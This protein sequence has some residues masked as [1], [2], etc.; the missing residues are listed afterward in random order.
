LKDKYTPTYRRESKRKRR[1]RNTA[2]NIQGN[3]LPPLLFCISLIPLK[4]QFN[5]LNTGYER[6]TKTKVSYVPYVDDLKLIGKREEEFQKKMQVVRNFR[7]YIHMEFG[8]DKCSK[9]ALKRGKLV[10]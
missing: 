7:D 2:W 6:T 8:P 4:E 10:Q 3:L 1:Y 9:I 5:K